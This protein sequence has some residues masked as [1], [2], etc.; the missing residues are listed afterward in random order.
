MSQSHAHQI[1]NAAMTARI[2]EALARPFGWTWVWRSLWLRRKCELVAVFLRT[3]A[4]HSAGLVLP[5]FRLVWLGT[6]AIAAVGIEAALT[7][8]RQSLAIRLTSLLSRRISG[9]A[10]Q[11]LMR[12]RIHLGIFPPDDVL[13]R[14]HV[15]F[16][17]HARTFGQRSHTRPIRG[18]R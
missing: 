13:N 10:F 17:S 18:A 14:F 4:V 15:T 11:H 1:G 16:A 2:G 7:S 9:K 3:D 6:G 5:I 8:L 12:M